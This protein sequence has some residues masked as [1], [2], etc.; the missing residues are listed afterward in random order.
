MARKKSKSSRQDK[1]QR[2]LKAVEKKPIHVR[3]KFLKKEF[4]LPSLKRVEDTRAI[5]REPVVP[6]SGKY[7][8]E[9]VYRTH[10]GIHR[11]DLAKDFKR[12]AKTRRKVGEA[13]YKGDLK[14]KRI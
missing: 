11:I 1:L 2:K 5:G 4:G 10:L 14:G 12:K 13:S 3:N 6:K 9:K 8:G 7:K